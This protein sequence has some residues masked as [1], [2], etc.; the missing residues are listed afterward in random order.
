MTH[1]RFHSADGHM[2]LCD[3]SKQVKLTNFS[4]AS[5]K[6]VFSQRNA[7]LYQR[8]LSHQSRIF[9]CHELSLV[10]DVTPGYGL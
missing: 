4:A 9:C 7:D 6:D 1:K 10:G 8:T 3:T 2:L 5:L